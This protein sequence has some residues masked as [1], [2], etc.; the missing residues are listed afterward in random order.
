MAFIK[1]NPFSMCQK[2]SLPY[3]ERHPMTPFTR[4]GHIHYCIFN[5]HVFAIFAGV[6]EN[7]CILLKYKNGAMA[8]LTDHTDIGKGNNMGLIYGQKDKIQVC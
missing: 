2:R 4:T 1:Q 7:A 3:L 5:L 6:D 8:N